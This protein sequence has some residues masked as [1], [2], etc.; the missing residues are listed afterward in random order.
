[1]LILDD[2][3]KEFSTFLS[4]DPKA[5]WRMDAALAYVITLA[6][7][8]GVDD[9]QIQERMGNL[10]PQRAMDYARTPSSETSGGNESPQGTQ[11]D[12]ASGNP[13]DLLHLQKKETNW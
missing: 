2:M 8:K 12:P 1:M 11:Q 9:G 6:Y 4:T 13:Q 3:R 10:H 7:Q 5:R